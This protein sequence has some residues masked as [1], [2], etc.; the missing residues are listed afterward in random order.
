MLCCVVNSE[1]QI[2]E[3]LKTVMLKDVEYIVVLVLRTVIPTTTG[4]Y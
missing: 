4:D 1:L 3:F 2:M